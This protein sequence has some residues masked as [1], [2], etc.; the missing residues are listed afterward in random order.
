MRL[1]A[2]VKSTDGFTIAEE[3][4][5]IRGPGEFF[6]TRQ[7]GLPELRIAN[8]LR[9]AKVLEE[10]RAAAFHLI[11]QDPLLSHPAHR[12]LK[13]MLLRKWQDRLELITIR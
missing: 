5:A 1:N 6:G 3:D 8:I 12:E 13:S 4:L 9:D 7:S 2:M 11:R 10:A